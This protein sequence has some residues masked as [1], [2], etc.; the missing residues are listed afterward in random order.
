M[1][2]LKPLFQKLQIRPILV[3]ERD[4]QPPGALLKTTT[5][6]QVE[7]SGPLCCREGQTTTGPWEH[8]TAQDEDAAVSFT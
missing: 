4:S 7:A 8:L 6:G 1:H 3:P 5:W 2:V